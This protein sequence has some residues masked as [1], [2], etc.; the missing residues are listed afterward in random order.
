MDYPP[1]KLLDPTIEQEQPDVN[2][3][4]GV[5]VPENG[6]IR[7]ELKGGASVQVSPAAVEKAKGRTENRRKRSTKK[8]KGPTPTADSETRPGAV[9]AEAE[10]REEPAP[11]FDTNENLAR[12]VD[13]Q[14]PESGLV[15]SATENAIRKELDKLRAAVEKSAQ[16]TEQETE[17]AASDTTEDSLTPFNAVQ[18]EAFTPKEGHDALRD[19]VSKFDQVPQ[20]PVA[21]AERAD[22]LSKETAY[23]AAFKELEQK[24]TIWNRLVMGKELKEES[25]RVNALKREYD[26]ARVVYANALTGIAKERVSAHV[27]NIEERT[28]EK[29]EK[30]KASGM[31]EGTKAENPISLETMLS[32]AKL[33]AGGREERI[34]KYLHFREV[35]RPLTEKKIQARQEALDARGKNAFERALGWSARQ[36]QKL[37][38]QFGKNGARA[39]RAA[40]TTVLI[41]LPVAALGSAAG[42]SLV[43]L[44]GYGTVRF[45]KAFLSSIAVAGAS[46]ATAQGYESL[47]GKPEQEKAR[48]SLKTEG[49]GAELSAESLAAIDASREKL[50][51]KADDRRLAKKK[52]IVRMLTAFGLGAGSAALLAEVAAVQHAADTVGSGTGGAAPSPATPA[53]TEAVPTTVL[54]SAAPEAVLPKEV[55][56][57]MPTAPEGMVQVATIGQ[58]EGFNQ[59]IVD[60]RSSGLSG[61]SAVVKHLLSENL[62]APDLSKELGALKGIE[63]GEMHVGDKLFVDK[64]GHLWFERDGVQHLVMENKGDSFVT[65]PIKGLEMHAYGA[66]QALAEKPVPHGDPSDAPNRA[67]AAGSQNQGAAFSVPAASTEVNPKEWSNQL[68]Q[69]SSDTDTSSAESLGEVSS[70]RG[71]L[72]DDIQSGTDSPAASSGVMTLD[73]YNSAL[74]AGQDPAASLAH[75]PGTAVSASGVETLDSY[76]ARIA[77][78]PESAASDIFTNPHGVEVSA[79]EP[80]AYEWKVPGTDLTYTV[81]HG[82]SLQETKIWVTEE[83]RLNPTANILVATPVVD[84]STGQL[85]TRM[86]AWHLGS[87]GKPEVNEG[88]LNP[89]TKRAFAAPDPNDF[90]RKIR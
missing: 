90:I 35:V 63:S 27:E 45:G 29:Y 78:A 18:G 40:A 60:L 31:L 66:P 38:A 61:D 72:A 67:Q 39:I 33:R 25:G 42:A 50:A 41:A 53:S 20:K 46:E 19:A 70:D 8:S 69:D 10:N 51:V 4:S 73:Q 49:R 28:L 55:H 9:D 88:I 15:S 32:R 48:V 5:S 34:A 77:E 11:A 6:M 58:G 47:I 59:L 52:Q 82:G 3:G 89:V 83:L 64:A 2:V 13:A 85:T 65:H 57:V 79:S 81:A 21:E 86:D 76:N 14:V 36:N 62:S 43:A 68:M 12:P 30:L 22:V 54:A 24:R 1:N 56:Y 23:L 75:A 16:G 26:E 7:Q 37:D 44:A 17:T 71:N 87:N 74:A 84:P 80:G